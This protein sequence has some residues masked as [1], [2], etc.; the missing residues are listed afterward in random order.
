MDYDDDEIDGCDLTMERDVDEI[1]D[2][3]DDLVDSLVLFAD[4]DFLDPVA[5]AKRKEEWEEVLSGA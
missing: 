4:V 1:P 5:V 3:P 2:C